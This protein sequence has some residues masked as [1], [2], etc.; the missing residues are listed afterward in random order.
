MTKEQ[1]LKAGEKE[2]EDEQT[3]KVKWNKLKSSRIPEGWW[4][5]SLKI[6]P[7]PENS[8]DSYLNWKP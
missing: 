1:Y 3:Y 4:I 7:S 5:K 6:L 8:Q 2:L